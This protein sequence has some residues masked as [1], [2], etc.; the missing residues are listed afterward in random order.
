ML[1]TW[2]TNTI[3]SSAAFWENE[4]LDFEV[5]DTRKCHNYSIPDDSVC[6]LNRTAKV[7]LSLI[8]T[9]VM[10]LIS[11][12]LAVATVF[13]DDSREPECCEFTLRNWPL[14]LF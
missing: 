8:S 4:I 2:V 5:T 11:A 9:D 13:I 10:V 6:E 3:V 14:F 7:H 1:D 12:N